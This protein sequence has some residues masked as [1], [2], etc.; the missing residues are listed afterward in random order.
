MKNIEVYGLPNCDTTKKMLKAFKQSAIPVE[1][2]DVKTGVITKDKLAGW[3]KQLGWEKLL[4]K[5]STTWRSL[6]PATQ[7]KITDEKTAIDLM[8]QHT[9]LIKRPI[10]IDSKKITVGY[11]ETYFTKQ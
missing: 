11:N 4:N 7:E 5:K 6:S 10:V 2:Y 9:A 3:S 1:F 8:L